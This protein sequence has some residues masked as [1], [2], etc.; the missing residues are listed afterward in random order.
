[1][2]AAAAIA[3]AI[4]AVLP[5]RLVPYWATPGAGENVKTA[6]HMTRIRFRLD[7]GRPLCEATALEIRNG[8][9]TGE[10]ERRRDV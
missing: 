8:C 7:S 5:Y 6:P 3:A 1:M 2:T 10:T 9:G 4:R